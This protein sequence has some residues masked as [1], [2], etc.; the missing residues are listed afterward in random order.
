MKRYIQTKKFYATLPHKLDAAEKEWLEAQ[1]DEP[2]LDWKW[3]E[4]NEFGE[5]GWTI[6]FTHK[7]VKDDQ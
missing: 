2:E 6:S 3:E 7:S 1:P 5:K 4:T